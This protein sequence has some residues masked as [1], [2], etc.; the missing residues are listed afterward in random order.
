MEDVSHIFRRYDIRGV[1]NKDLNV[2]IM[3]RI[4]VAVA[5]FHRADYVVGGDGR[6]ST[7]PLKLALISGLLSA[8][9]DVTDIGVVPIGAAIYAN[10]R[11]RKA[12][13][14]VTASHLPPEWNGVKLSRSNGDLIVGE[15]V[16]AIRKLFYS[17][18]RL[19]RA[20]YD[21]VGK[22]SKL[23]ILPSYMDFLSEQMESSNLRIVVDCGNGVASLVAPYVLRENSHE[24]YCVNCDVDPR[25][26]G[27]GSEPTLENIKELEDA[28]KKFKA[29]F[30]VAFDGDGDRTIFVDE[31][32]VPLTAEQAAIV[33]LEGGEFGDI[34]ANVECSMVLEEYVKSHG[35]KVYR[36]PVGRTFMVNKMKETGA[37]LGVESSGHYVVRRGINYDDGLLTLVH[38]ADAVASLEKPISKIVPQVYPLLRDKVPVN[39]RIKFELM[40]HFK[41]KL[42][43]EYGDVETVDGVRVNFE[44]SW[45]LVRP[46]N[47]EPIIRLTAEAQTKEKALELLRKFKALLVKEAEKFKA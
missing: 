18:S 33:M 42:K 46:S 10:L 19:E 31:Q 8:G 11:L 15:G 4:G 38:F 43:A 28:A 27:R 14:Y 36:V 30:G 16:Y 44:N 34:V 26:P 41:E 40:E 6:G 9:A 47:T 35:K 3:A 2:E 17:D 29:N 24:V 7:I 45:I 25:F 12:M 1:F 5:N 37:V 32:G 39:D 23:D 21:G 20:R 13:A 22:L